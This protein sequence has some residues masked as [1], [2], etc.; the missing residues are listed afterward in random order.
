MIILLLFLLAYWRP[1]ISF[2]RDFDFIDVDFQEFHH[3]LSKR[4]I[5]RKPDLDSDYAN[6]NVSPNSPDNVVLNNPV[7]CVNSAFE[8]FR[9]RL[10]KEVPE[11]SNISISLRLSSSALK[12]QQT[13]FETYNVSAF[14]KFCKVYPSLPARLK[15]CPYSPTLSMAQTVLKLFSFFCVDHLNDFK[16][17]IPCYQ[18]S[19][20]ALSKTCDSN[21]QPVGANNSSIGHQ[22]KKNVTMDD[23]KVILKQDC[24]FVDCEIKCKSIALKAQCG[25]DSVKLVKQTVSII[26]SILLDIAK[27]NNMS[28]V[29]NSKCQSL[30]LNV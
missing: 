9:A 11:M 15:L 26:F 24:D 7:E 3:I 28:S 18:K 25:D 17:Y 30:I 5:T 19:N 21:C 2:A 23:L 14:E 10:R 4:A 22:G 20:D 29:W 1:V 8:K 6:E 12:S 27:N 13:L 16:K